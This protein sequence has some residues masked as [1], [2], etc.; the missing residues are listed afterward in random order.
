MDQ[1]KTFLRQC[2]KYRFWIAVGVSLLLPM[3]GYFVGS[4]T[5]TAATTKREGE[6]KKA[7]GDVGKF[8]APG[9]PNPDYTKLVGEK[10]EFLAKDVDATQRKLYQLQEPLLKWPEVVESKFRAWGRKWPENIDQGV[11][12]QTIADYTIAYPEFVTRVYQTVK[13]WNPED[14]KGIVFVPDQTALI[15]PAPFTLESRPE[16]GKVWAEQERLWVVTALLD[17]VAK[18]NQDAGAKDWDGAWIKQI[19]DIDVGSAAAQDQKSLAKGVELEPAPPLVPEGTPVPDPAAASPA[20]MMGGAG[21]MMGGKMGG[22]AGAANEVYSLKSEA[23]LPYK[24]LPIEMTVLVDQSHLSEFLVGLENSPM[25]I[26]V[27]EP[28]I[29]KPSIAVVKPVYGESS[30]GMGGMGGYMGGMGG[31]GGGRN[32]MMGNGGGRSPMEMMGGRSQ[33]GRQGGGGAPQPGMEGGNMAAMMG[34]MRGGMMNTPKKTGTDLRSVV[35]KAE[36]RKKQAKDAAKAKAA[37]KKS[38][39]QYYNVIEVTVYGQARFYNTPAPIPPAEPSTSTA[40]ATAT[41][42]TAAPTEP[43]ATKPPATAPPVET[44]SPAASTP[45]TGGQP[46]TPAVA[47]APEPAKPTTPPTEAD[48]AP[49][50]DP[51]K[52]DPASPKA[53]PSAPK[54]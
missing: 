25:A 23:S 11:V 8:T 2:V 5:Y 42:T 29:G 3:I 48:P 50:A 6:I 36:E 4:G 19:I 37:P 20:S 34:G 32:A 15:K 27:M 17:V 35:N 45:P 54:S 43:A 44:V 1:L 16:L 30:F 40:T 9:Q 46:S 7:D 21:G 31:S 53:D 38:V 28:E 18:V 10:T 24:V 13:P 26:Q 52:P 47:P 51:T 33:M 14:G 41:E 49:K 12:Q 22:A 39:D